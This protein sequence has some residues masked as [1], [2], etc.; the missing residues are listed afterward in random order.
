MAEAVREKAMNAMKALV[1]NAVS[2]IF[3]AKK[4]GKKMKRFL[5]YWWGRMSF[6]SDDVFM[7]R[8]YDVKC[9]TLG[10]IIH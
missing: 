7:M 10:K 8:P 2:V 9:I 3:N 5:M 6:M 1:N 4:S